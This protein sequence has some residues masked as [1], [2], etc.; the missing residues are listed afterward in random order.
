M[1]LETYHRKRDFSRTAEPK[2]KILPASDR[3]RFV[4]QKHAARRLHYDLRLEMDG[5]LKS[6]AVTRGPSLIPGEKR[7]AVHVEDHP[8]DYAA[9][10]GTIP[11]GEYG[12]G[13]VL[14]WDEGT[15]SP[16]GD[17]AKGMRKG[18]L[19]F[20][21]HGQK[22]MGRW[23]LVRM[24]QRPEE[25]RENWLLIKGEDK[26]SR[27]KGSADI[28]EE[29]PESVVSG[30]DIS[31][32]AETRTGQ[33]DSPGPA[34]K[35]RTSRKGAS[36][37]GDPVPMRGA[38][39]AALPDFVAPMLAT[40]VK[41]A[42][43]GRDW[44]HEIKFDGYRLQARLDGGKVT[45]LTR[46][47]LDWT[48]RFGD[49]L[50][51]ALRRLPVDNALLDGELV[52]ENSSGASDFP[53]LQADLSEG[54]S[55]RFALYLFDLLFLNGQ[56]LRKVPL[57]DRKTRLDRLLAGAEEPLRY[58]DHFR[59]NG[60]LILQH[61]CRLSL[62]GIVSKRADG[63]YLS[64]RGKAWVK[65]KCSDRQEFVIGGFVP[66]TVLREAI[67]SLLLGV[68]DAGRLRYVGRVGTGFTQTTAKALH[69]Q[70]SRIKSAESPFGTGLSAEERR[71]AIFTRPELIAEV[72][73]RAWTADAHLRHASFRGLREDKEARDVV[74]EGSSGAAAAA[75]PRRRVKLTHP[76]RV[77]WPDTG[78]TKEGLADYYEGMWPAIS[79]FIVGRPLALVRCPDGI[80]GQTF[81][82]KHAWKGMNP[83]IRQIQDPKDK[84]GE[85][86][87][88]VDDLDGLIGLV[89]AA[90]L[91]IHPW[92][93]T[94]TDWERPDM[95]I[96]DLDP[97]ENVPWADVIVAAHE[98]RERLGKAGLAAFVKTSGG[99]GLH[100]VTPLVPAADWTAVKAFTQALAKD[101]AADSPDHYV[102]TIT[103]SKR[104]GKILIDYLRNQRGATAVAPYSTRA[105]PGAPVSA[106]IAWEELGSEI[107]P[108][109]FTLVNMPSRQS[110]IAANPWAD[111]RTAAVPLASP[112][113]SRSSRR[114]R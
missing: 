110:A 79:P 2:G 71:G 75:T 105:R 89:Q 68:F 35:K 26:H 11:A 41:S 12:G 80:A 106:P 78:L 37:D 61:A 1:T 45:L 42:P 18:H 98:V 49:R 95:I 107:G 77:Y 112:T 85:P 53:A 76:D 87:V 3:A 109:Y 84:A 31:E 21:L 99:K 56:D 5:V 67:G 32:I 15:W 74:Q 94:I 43:T 102:A 52:V 39:A 36:P 7:L 20:A 38:V 63:P 10:E 44:L 29:Q 40:L 24:A 28:L 23:H 83:A 55:E 104:K 81:F 96:M 108:A 30:R 8:L 69:D 59:E 86:L 25:K 27:A 16:I 58:S 47:G 72:E 62:E 113:L 48:S 57:V 34:P 114:G 66:S 91:E 97:G 60:N 19:E 88:G 4:I 103:K 90:A 22:L 14:V 13:S 46:S 73:F 101:M 70:L 64:G 33:S 51:S 92:G 6:W 111:F 9:F 65:S 54:R 50:L 17:P 100:V 93:S 82:Q